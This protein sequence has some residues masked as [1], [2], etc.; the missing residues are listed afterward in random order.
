[1]DP[2]GRLRLGMVG[3]IVSV[4]LAFA[5]AC[6]GS[7][8]PDP[9]GSGPSPTTAE[10]WFAT[11]RDAQRQGVVN[12]PPFLDPD[13]VIDHRGL[14][15]LRKHEAVVVAG[16]EAAL[17]YLG[18]QWS[19]VRRVRTAAAPVYP[20]QAGA[21]DLAL[22]AFPDDYGFSGSSSSS[23]VPT[24]WCPSGMRGPSCPGVR[25]RSRTRAGSTC[26]CAHAGTSRPG[27]RPTAARCGS[28]TRRTRPQQM[29]WPRSRRWG[30]PRSGRWPRPVSLPAVCPG[31]RWTRCLTWA[32]RPTSR[33][34]GRRRVRTRRRWRPRSCS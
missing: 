26:T 6:G 18:T 2:W 4:A 31:S 13:V 16:R 25:P 22:I 28:C 21:V 33:L 14:L 30:R 27:R 15:G 17:A 19:P 24:G 12:L 3:G 11:Y 8:V 10:S 5:A 29:T 7:S 9:S 32:A 20:S 34:G 1:M 23:S